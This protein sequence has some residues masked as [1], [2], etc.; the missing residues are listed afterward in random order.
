MNKELIK[1]R[2]EDIYNEMNESSLSMIRSTFCNYRLHDDKIQLLETI[3]DVFYQDDIEID[4]RLYDMN[5]ILLTTKKY[6]LKIDVHESFMKN[7]TLRDSLINNLYRT[8]NSFTNFLNVNEIFEE[9]SLE[10]YHDN[11]NIQT[12]SMIV[13]DDF[14]NSL[15]KYESE[16]KS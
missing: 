13:S 6:L 7:K 15:K 5:L 10:H 14:Y 9:I 1:L 2:Y 8:I 4:E 3:K 12:I 11:F 16:L